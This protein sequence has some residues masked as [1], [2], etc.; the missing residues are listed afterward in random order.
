MLSNSNFDGSFYCIIIY[1]GI[2]FYD[3]FVLKYN[4][5]NYYYIIR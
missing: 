5:N 2:C 3:L 1:E 4:S